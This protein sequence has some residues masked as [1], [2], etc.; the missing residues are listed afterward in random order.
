MQSLCGLTETSQGHPMSVFAYAC[1]HNTSIHVTLFELLKVNRATPPL[2][3]YPSYA[4][5]HS[6]WNY[7]LAD[8]LS[9]FNNTSMEILSKITSS[10]WEVMDSRK[11]LP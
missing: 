10:Y 4:H 7:S 6:D 8:M 9:P 1:I 11:G 3:K 2:G 5:E